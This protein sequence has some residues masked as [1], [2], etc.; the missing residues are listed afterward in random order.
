[1]N[2]CQFINSFINTKN[3][4]LIEE[5]YKCN[6]KYCNENDRKY[7]NFNKNI[8]TKINYIELNIENRLNLIWTKSMLFI[9]KYLHLFEF[10]SNN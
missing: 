9:Y 10:Y 4:N 8:N 1:M 7:I 6:C 3:V 5:I 2:E